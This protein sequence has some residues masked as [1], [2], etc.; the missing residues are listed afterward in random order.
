MNLA[1]VSRL[2]CVLPLA[3]VTIGCVSK[4]PIPYAFSP[5]RGAAPGAP[6]LRVMGLQDLRAKKDDMDKLME[7]PPAV[8]EVLE[9]EL[10]NSGMFSRVEGMSPQAGSADFILNGE[11]H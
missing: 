2:I 3:L 11:L 1:T 7:L 10:R 9:K 4:K 8:A 5:A 6:T